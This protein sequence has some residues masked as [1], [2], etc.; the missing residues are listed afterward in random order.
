MYYNYLNINYYVTNICFFRAYKA[1]N[2]FLQ[3]CLL[4]SEITLI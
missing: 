4:L 2:F 3:I 1:T